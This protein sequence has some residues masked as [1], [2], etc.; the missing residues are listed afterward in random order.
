MVGMEDRL[1]PRLA[2]FAHRVARSL[3]PRLGRHY[4]IQ[5]GKRVIEM[6]PAGKDKGVA[7]RE[8]MREAPFRG[9]TAVFVGDDATDEYGFAIVNRLHGH[10]I[11]V[12]S[13]QTAAR[14]RLRDVKAVQAWLR[15]I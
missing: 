13:G 9:R 11:K 6:K 1:A 7:V 15:S 5:T 3:L 4:G 8:F 12:G 10:S 2:S 14:W